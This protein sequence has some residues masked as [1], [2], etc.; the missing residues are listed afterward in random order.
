MKQLRRW[1]AGAALAAALLVHACGEVTTILDQPIEYRTELD[2]TSQVLSGSGDTLVGDRVRFGVTVTR[3]GQPFEAG[4]P[5]F[6]SSDPEVVEILNA[7]TGDALFAGVGQATVSVAF[8][9]PRQPD[10]LLRASLVVPVD[11]FA[12]DVQLTALSSGTSGDTLVGDTVQFVTRV[13][14]GDGRE[15]S[16]VFRY[17]SSDASIVEILDATAGTALLTG[18]GNAEV[19]VT[20]LDPPVPDGPLT[21]VLPVHVE[22]FA[23]NIDLASVSSGRVEVGDTL[24]TDSVQFSVAVQLQ[25][26]AVDVV[27]PVFTSSDPAIIEILDAEAG[28]AVLADTGTATVSVT[29]TEPEL[30]RQDESRRV[31]VTTYRVDV[32]GPG[33]PVMGDTVDYSVNVVATRDGS[34][35]PVSGQQFQSTDASVLRVLDQNSGRTFVRDVGQAEVGVSLTSPTLP[36]QNLSGTLPVI[37]TQERFYGAASQTAGDFG[38]TI[39]LSSSEVHRFS[40]G[41]RVRFPNGAAGYVESVTLNQLEFVVGAGANSGPLTLTNLV[42]D[43]GGDRGDVQT[44][45]TFDAGGTVADAFEPNDAL[46]LAE[47]DEIGSFPFEALLSSDP[48]K[49]APADTN[50]FYFVIN[51]KT[52]IDVTAQWQQD[53]DLDFKVCEV[54]GNPP[55][56]YP[57]GGPVCPYGPADNSQDRTREEAQGVQLDR[58]IYIV[59]FYCVDCPSVPLT[60]RVNIT[61]P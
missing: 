36:H 24:V 23:I 38:D 34:S 19:T 43:Q 7:E 46:P 35:L 12:V 22:D 26:E 21:A 20:L 27:D 11:S 56:S 59:A 30:P 31:R 41:T 9:E 33:S 25:G 16:A 53:A 13:T 42:D 55:V 6:E 50:F 32:N 17:T 54:L 44:L 2:V 60:Y 10:S 37:V 48:S 57:S 5:L 51:K 1:L 49:S 4:G 47:K 58:A 29:F 8:T 45:W 61:E 18:P 3:E 39:S 28:R 52:S 14:R 40:A 15:V